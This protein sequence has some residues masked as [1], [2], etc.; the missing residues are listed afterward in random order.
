MVK[1][2]PYYLFMVLSLLFRNIVRN[3]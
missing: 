2:P 1:V 3:V